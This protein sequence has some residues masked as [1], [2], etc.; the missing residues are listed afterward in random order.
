MERVGRVIG[1][2]LALLGVL[3]L[4]RELRRPADQRTWHGSIC[5]V[6]WDYRMP[7]R[8]RIRERLW[9]AEDAR[10]VVPTVV[11]LGWTVNLYQVARKLGR[12]GVR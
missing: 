4:M 2:L 10:L 6:P 3:A 12:I 5:G 1:V 9:N 11:G 7:T 8:T